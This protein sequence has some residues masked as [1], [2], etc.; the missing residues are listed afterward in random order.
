[1]L[2]PHQSEIVI[3]HR[4]DEA[5]REFCPGEVDYRDGLT[6]SGVRGNLKRTAEVLAERVY[7]QISGETGA[8]M[9]EILAQRSLSRTAASSKQPIFSK[10]AQGILALVGFLR[11][12]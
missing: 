1:M 11:G 9:K 12:G 8:S 7:K 3:S 4:K 10:E 2:L 6:I 5:A